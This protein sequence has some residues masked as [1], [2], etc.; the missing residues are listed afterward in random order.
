MTSYDIYARTL[1]YKA[2]LRQ[3]EGNLLTI[4]NITAKIEETTFKEER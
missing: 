3:V 4:D 1:F 2:Q